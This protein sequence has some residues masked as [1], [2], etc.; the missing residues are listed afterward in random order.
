M[1]KPPR[2]QELTGLH[3]E[4]QTSV[5]YINSDILSPKPSQAS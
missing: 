1:E 2:V 5:G 3:S 4:F